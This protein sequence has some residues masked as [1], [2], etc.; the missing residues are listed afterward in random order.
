MRKIAGIFLLCGLL[1]FVGCGG[2]GTDG[3]TI[4]P[5]MFNI[6]TPQKPNTETV[7][8]EKPFFITQKNWQMRVAK[9]APGDNFC[10]I[11]VYTNKNGK[12]EAKTVFYSLVRIA[13]GRLQARPFHHDYV[14][15]KE[16]WHRGQPLFDLATEFSQ[17]EFRRQMDPGDSKVQWTALVII[18]QPKQPSVAPHYTPQ[19]PKKECGAYST[20]SGWWGRHYQGQLFYQIDTRDDFDASG[21]RLLKIKLNHWNGTRVVSFD[22]RVVSAPMNYKGGVPFSNK[23]LGEL[24]PGVTFHSDGSPERWGATETTTIDAGRISL[25]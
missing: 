11:K 21:N 16:N 25:N 9:Y 22:C 18:P 8:K 12:L 2:G 15:V 19:N 1:L 20:H 5:G 13:D 4:N 3:S 14:P 10:Q 24:F 6:Y 17:Y 7:K 23:T